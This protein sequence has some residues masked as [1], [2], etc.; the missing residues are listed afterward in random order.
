M[1]VFFFAFALLHLLVYA[2]EQNDDCSERRPPSYFQEA[3]RSAA[4]V[5]AESSESCRTPITD[6]GRD[7]TA[8]SF[9]YQKLKGGE[10]K[11]KFNYS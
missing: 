4:Q 3:D 9:T 8:V 6:G 1:F 2:V 11:W 10:K 7:F 5:A